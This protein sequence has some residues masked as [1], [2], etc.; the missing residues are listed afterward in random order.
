MVHFLR[1]RNIAQ[2]QESLTRLNKCS[3][4]A[5]NKDLTGL[6]KGG[7]VVKQVPFPSMTGRFQR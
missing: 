3:N 7:K 4:A 6:E 5:F 2:V 1:L